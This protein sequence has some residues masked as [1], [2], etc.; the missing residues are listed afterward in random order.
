M[1]AY[2]KRLRDWGGRGMWWV[3]TII[4]LGEVTETKMTKGRKWFENKDESF[5]IIVMLNWNHMWEEWTQWH[6]LGFNIDLTPKY[7]ILFWFNYLH[8]FPNINKNKNQE[9]NIIGNQSNTTNFV[10]HP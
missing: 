9:K 4:S 3:G 8:N 2:F 10:L 5:K 7:L 6:E 1:G